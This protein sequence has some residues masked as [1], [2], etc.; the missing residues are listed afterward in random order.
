MDGRFGD[1]VIRIRSVKE[2]ADR[3]AMETARDRGSSAAPCPRAPRYRSLIN[4]RLL[5]I[6]PGCQK[7]VVQ[8]AGVRREWEGG[9]MGSTDA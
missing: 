6:G 4:L 9:S 7:T 3:A 2:F 5:L 8:V 1:R